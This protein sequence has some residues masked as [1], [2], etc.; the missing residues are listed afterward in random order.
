MVTK[1][2]NNELQWIQDW[3][4]FH[5][6]MHGIDG[7]VLVDNGS[8]A[9]GADELAAAMDEVPGYRRRVLIRTPLRFGPLEVHCTKSSLATFLQVSVLNIV[10]DRF[11]LTA[12]T[13]LNVDVDELVVGRDGASITDATA[14]GLVGFRTF[15]GCWRHA[16]PGQGPVT[17]A[18]HYLTDPSDPPCAT[19]Y[20]LRPGSFVGGRELRVHTVAHLDRNLFLDR[21]FSF[22][23]CR[24]V[25]TSWKYD[26]SAADIGR[27]VEVPEDRALLE[28]AFG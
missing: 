16:R 10:R 9:Y 23:H 26:R 1:S 24:Q 20:C 21:R 11:L 12:R 8:D 13:M 25:S 7:L 28:R 17:H 27:L 18:D 14:R 19:K 3:M 22:L 5:N 15:R 2:R 4:G 6:R